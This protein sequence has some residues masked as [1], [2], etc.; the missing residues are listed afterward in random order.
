MSES[1]LVNIL[2]LGN[3]NS[4]IQSGNV[5]LHHIAS[6]SMLWNVINLLWKG[7]NEISFTKKIVNTTSCERIDLFRNNYNR[8][9]REYLI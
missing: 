1:L 8:L 6:L 5:T 7:D 4:L 3:N 2:A 9:K